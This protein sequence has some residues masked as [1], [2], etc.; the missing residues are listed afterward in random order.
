MK[1]ARNGHVVHAAWALVSMMYGYVPAMFPMSTK[2]A[3]RTVLASS[4]LVVGSV[5]LIS[6][7]SGACF[8]FASKSS[9]ATRGAL[10]VGVDDGG[11]W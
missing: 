11:H 7:L 10:R 8:G 3:G 6:C 1:R 5:V 2:R 9:A 4:R